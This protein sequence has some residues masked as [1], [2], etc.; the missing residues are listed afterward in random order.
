MLKVDRLSTEYVYTCLARELKDQM[1]SYDKNDW[2]N[3]ERALILGCTQVLYNL[4][5]IYA[6]YRLGVIKAV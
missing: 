3:D 6:L 5:E 1:T 4:R 2:V